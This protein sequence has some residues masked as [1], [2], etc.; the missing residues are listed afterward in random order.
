M[1]DTA[2]GPDWLRALWDNIVDAR[3]IE[4]TFEVILISRPRS[5]E[6]I[7]SP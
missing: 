4:R 2:N 1:C 5:R 7:D 6:G 3:V